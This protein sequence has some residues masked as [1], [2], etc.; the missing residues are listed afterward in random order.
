MIKLTLA[1]AIQMLDAKSK[2]PIKGLS[3]MKLKDVRI[4]NDIIVVGFN[5]WHI[6]Y[7]VAVKYGMLIVHLQQIGSNYQD[8]PDPVPDDIE[9]AIGIKLNN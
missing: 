7:A 1:S 3:K 4:G 2:E 6:A 8:I 5:D 9:F